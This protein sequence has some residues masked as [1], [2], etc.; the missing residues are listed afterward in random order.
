MKGEKGKQ[1]NFYKK[2]SCSNAKWLPPQNPIHPSFP[3]GKIS[4]A[5]SQSVMCVCKCL[6]TRAARARKEILFTFSLRIVE[7]KW[8]AGVMKKKTPFPPITILM[9]NQEFSLIH[10]SLK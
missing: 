4:P 7:I 8:N 9:D 1:R 3:P 5:V 6:F 10:R 2:R